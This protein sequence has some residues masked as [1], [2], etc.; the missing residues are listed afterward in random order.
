MLAT[1]GPQRYCTAKT[2][3]LGCT[4]SIGWSGAPSASLA[5]SF[6]I[7]ASEVLGQKTGFLVYALGS[8]FL[9][10]QGGTLCVAAPFVRTP[11]QGSQGAA[12]Q[13]NGLFGYEFNARIQSGVDPALVAGATVS[14]QYYFRDPADPAGFGSGLSDALRF[15]ICP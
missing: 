11:P 15:V 7:T 12:G 8:R 3:S 13:C 9:P 2:S 5:Q 4:P 14:A 1:A 10:F 6:R